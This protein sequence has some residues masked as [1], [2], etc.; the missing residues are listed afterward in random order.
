MQLSAMLK[1]MALSHV[2]SG[3]AA[4]F[5]HRHLSRA[6]VARASTTNL[7]GVGTAARSTGVGVARPAVVH[8]GHGAVGRGAGEGQD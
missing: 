5:P 4:A 3:K 8:D 7:D 1:W 2:K 6:V